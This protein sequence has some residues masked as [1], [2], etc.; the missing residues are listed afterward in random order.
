MLTPFQIKPKIRIKQQKK[1]VQLTTPL[2]YLI[3]SILVLFRNTL[4]R[5]SWYFGFCWLLLLPFVEKSSVKPRSPM[6]PLK[7]VDDGSS[8]HMTFLKDWI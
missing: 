2:P 5:F 8:I 3:M 1:L 4:S 6:G 7:L